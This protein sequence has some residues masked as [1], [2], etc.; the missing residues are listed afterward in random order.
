MREW[1]TGCSGGLKSSHVLE[2]TYWSNLMRR[3]KKF[4]VWLKVIFIVTWILKY[5]SSDVNQSSKQSDYLGWILL[6]YFNWTIH[7]RE[8]DTGCSGG[9]KS[10]HVLEDTY[11][12]NLMKYRSVIGEQRVE[13]HRGFRGYLV[14][15]LERH[16][17]VFIT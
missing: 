16:W 17:K 4:I 3:K 8:W 1:D 14:G 2:D 12:S 7:M 5:Y 15:N 9:L 13:G 6:F 11:W 10:S